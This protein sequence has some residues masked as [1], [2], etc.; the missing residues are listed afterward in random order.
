MNLRR[1]LLTAAV[2]SAS[3][4]AFAA[5]T[6]ERISFV[7]CP[8]VRDTATV[9]CW[10]SEYEGTNYYLTIQS[11]VSAVVQPPM[12]GHQVLVE[13]VVTDQPAICGGVVLEDVRLSVMPELDRNCNTVLPVDPRIV[14]DFNPRPPGPSAGRLAFAPPPDAPEPPPLE[15]RQS[16]DIHFDFDKG[17][18]FRHPGELSNILR[19]AQQIGATRMQVTGVRG[20][21]RLSNGTLLQESENIAQR[22][23]TEI[24]GLLQGAGLDVPALTQTRDGSAEADG[25]DDWQTRRVTVELFTD[26]LGSGPEPAVAYSTDTLPTHTIYRPAAL[27][28]SYPVVLW[29]NGSCVNSNFGY[30]EFLAEVASQGFI[31]LAIGPWRDT[32]APRH[33]RPEDPAQWPPFETSWQ[34][35]FE[36]LDWLAAENARA[37]SE[38]QGHVATDKVAVMGHSCGGLQAIRASTDP[39]IST[40]LVLN[41]G[42]MPTDDDQYM[43]RHDVKRS[44]LRDMHAPIAYFIGGETDIAHA[45]AEIDWQELQALQLPAIN[46]NL[47]VGHGAT[48]NQPHGGPF[49]A[50]PLAWLKWQLRDDADARAMFVGENCGFCSGTD[51]NLRRHLP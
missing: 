8:A 27:T 21:H 43:L 41:S 20:A 10:T 17:V 32:P 50:G 18:S 25:V 40:V 9:P 22:R 33:Q 23:A 16:I 15:G 2:A 31:V 36:G 13:G 1:I 12:L 47:D 26:P 3:A 5:E 38:L 46:A 30:R 51:W 28:G 34:Q 49:A 45:N 35:H 19:I 44:I 14:I 24:A 6:G 37:G 7:S 48:Y 4:G 11:D 29:G 42:M 39:R